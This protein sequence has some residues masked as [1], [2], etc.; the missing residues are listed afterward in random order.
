[1]KII[2]SL[3]LLFSFI[4]FQFKDFTKPD[5]VNNLAIE[6]S[7]FIAEKYE[8]TP[9]GIGGSFKEGISLI[10][11]KFNFNGKPL[12]IGEGRKMIINVSEDVLKFINSNQ[13]IRHLLKNYPFNIDNIDIDIFC[14]NSEGKVINDPYLKII[15][16][17]HKEISY[18]TQDPN[19]SL[20]YKQEIFETY[21]EALRKVKNN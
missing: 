9:I 12:D 17:D 5:P 16:N 11:V 2:L 15:S 21:I 4:F 13:N 7:K 14:Y 19:N 6:V 10:K 8:L 18:F 1:M 3:I 20:R